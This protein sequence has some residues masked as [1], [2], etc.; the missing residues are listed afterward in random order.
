V[1]AEYAYSLED[2]GHDKFELG[3][4]AQ[5]DVDRH[6]GRVNLTFERELTGGGA[7]EMEYAWQYR[8]RRGERFEPGIEMY[9]G[10]GEWG[11]MGS[12]N[13]HEQQLGPACFGKLRTA[14]GAWKYEAAILLGLNEASP[15]TTLRVLLEY[16]F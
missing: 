10:L 15:D 8:Y 6:E 14:T 13:D 12:F 9:G 5:K 4:L 7:T 1:L 11:H 3:L 16:E 2:H